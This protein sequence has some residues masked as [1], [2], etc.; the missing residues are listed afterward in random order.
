MEIEQLFLT[1]KDIYVIKIN[2]GWM[3]LCVMEM[4]LE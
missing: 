2:S 4:K 1:H 3:M